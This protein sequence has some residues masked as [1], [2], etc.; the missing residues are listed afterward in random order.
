[1]FAYLP[2][3]SLESARISN[4]EIKMADSVDIDLYDNIEDEFNQVRL[5]LCMFN[6]YFELIG[7]L[8]NSRDGT[9]RHV[10]YRYIKFPAEV[11]CGVTLL[12]SAWLCS[13]SAGPFILFFPLF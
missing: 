12:A 4:P 13:G 5:N 10:R 6:T 2:C 8:T 7:S 11:F 3:F 1:M 9:V